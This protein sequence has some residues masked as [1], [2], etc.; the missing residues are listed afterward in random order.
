MKKNTIALLFTC[1]SLN[2]CVSEVRETTKLSVKAHEKVQQITIVTKTADNAI[3]PGGLFKQ[4]YYRAMLNQLELD[5]KTAGIVVDEIQFKAD[6]TS[7][8]PNAEE[9]RLLQK[10]NVRNTLLIDIFNLSR[11]QYSVSYNLGV[12]V[13]DLK[14]SK[15]FYDGNQSV[16]HTIDFSTHE[17]MREL[18]D[19]VFTSI[20]PALGIE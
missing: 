8:D 12:S 15:Q 3:D 5:I 17:K 13:I 14:S 4:Q 2:A 9:V 20:K 18:G 1:M 19:K 6:E 11:D 10:K 16:A 7:L